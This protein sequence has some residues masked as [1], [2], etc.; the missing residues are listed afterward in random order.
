[1]APVRIL[2]SIRNDSP[3][4]RSWRDFES[5][6][7]LAAELVDYYEDYLRTIAE[8]PGTLKEYSSNEFDAFL[9]EFFDELVCL[10]KDTEVPTGADLWI[11]Y[12]LPKIKESIYNYFRSTLEEQPTSSSTAAEMILLDQIPLPPENQPLPINDKVSLIAPKPL[13]T[14]PFFDKDNSTRSR[15]RSSTEADADDDDDNYYN[16]LDYSEDEEFRR[17][18]AQPMEV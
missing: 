11:P 8:D 4:S 17:S 6:L 5:D 12:G 16:E 18:S 2:Y 13:I 15:N 3:K 9:D 14:S 7:A 1:M 10:T